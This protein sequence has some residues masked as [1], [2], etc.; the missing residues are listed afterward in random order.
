MSKRLILMRHAKSD[1]AHDLSDHDRPLNRRGTQA[2]GALGQWLRLNDYVPDQVWCSS[3]QRTQDTL[4]GLDVA[5]DQQITRSLYLAD[6][7]ALLA[8][9]KLAQGDCI[10]MVAHNPG[11]AWFA[12]QMVTSAPAHPKF[13]QYPTGATL[14]ADF[15]ITDW[16]EVQ[17][18]TGKVV[19]FI[20][21]R[22]LEA[23]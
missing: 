10:L 22:E 8:A 19:D 17:A 15:D 16:A 14:V 1:W 23:Q 11:I 12:G 5:G 7:E 6:P 20:V 13:H 4:A 9:L 3:A 18:G 2:A 21:P